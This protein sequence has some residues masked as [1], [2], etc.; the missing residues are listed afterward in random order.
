MRLR[1]LKTIPPEILPIDRPARTSR[2]RS[3]TH[4][5]C[6]LPTVVLTVAL[7]I[8][9]SGCNRVKATTATPV[10][11]VEVAAVETRDVPAY[12]EWVARLDGYVKA[13]LQPQVSG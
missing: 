10:P 13:Q 7:G 12:S 2:L 8:F 5:K 1:D 6:D 9:V 11:E 4:G 3:L